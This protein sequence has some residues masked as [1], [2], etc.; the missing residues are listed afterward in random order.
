MDDW[1]DQEDWVPDGDGFT[2]APSAARGFTPEKD[3]KKANSRAG[4]CRPIKP[5]VIRL[6][7]LRR[8][9]IEFEAAKNEAPVLPHD[10]SGRRRDITKPSCSFQ[11]HAACALNARSRK[12]NPA[13]SEPAPDL[14]W[15]PAESMSTKPHGTTDFPS[16]PS[17]TKVRR[18]ICVASCLSTR[19][20][21]RA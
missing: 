1:C 17:T 18:R 19:K 16:S 9:S 7:P 3:R 15:S 13:T 11:G 21:R 5:K 20:K 2:A 12:N 14:P 6:K 4:N 10:A 8:A